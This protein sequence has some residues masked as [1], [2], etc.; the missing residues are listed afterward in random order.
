MMEFNAVYYLQTPYKYTNHIVRLRIL[1][2]NMG[3][4]KTHDGLN[5]SLSYTSFKGLKVYLV[6][7][8]SKRRF[9][10]FGHNGGTCNSS[11][12]V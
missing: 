12:N 6:P 4:A 9:D 11:A 1:S 2:C 3:S 5:T 7:N 8:I 10:A